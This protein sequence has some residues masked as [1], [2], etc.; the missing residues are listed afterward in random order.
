MRLQEAR[1]LPPRIGG[2][3]LG[4]FELRP[5][6]GDLLRAAA[7]VQAIDDGLLRRE[8]AL[9]PAR[10]GAESAR[11]EPGQDLARLMH[12]SPSWTSTAAIRSLPLKARSTCRRS[13][14]P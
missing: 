1:C 14:L 2:V 6:L 8:P 13:T 5:C 3:G 9:R 7:V 10:P 12:A 4:G 11:I